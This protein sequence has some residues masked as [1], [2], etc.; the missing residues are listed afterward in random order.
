MPTPLVVGPG[1]EAG[2]REGDL[3]ADESEAFVGSTDV[4]FEVGV[5]GELLFA[6]RVGAGMG[7]AVLDGLARVVHVDVLVE[8]PF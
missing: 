3:A 4:G 7:L 8:F 2:S 5:F 1:F 6:A